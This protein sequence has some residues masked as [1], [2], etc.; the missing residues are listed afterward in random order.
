M[1]ARENALS[2]EIE[3]VSWGKARKPWWLEREQEGVPAQRHDY[4][5][6]LDVAD[7]PTYI[8]HVWIDALHVSGARTFLA[9]RHRSQSQ[10]VHAEAKFRELKAKW[11]E[12]TFFASSVVDR[13]LHPSYQ[14]IIG[15]GPQV[16]P[17]LLKDLSNEDSDWF[18]ALEHISGENPVPQ[19]EWG[20]RARMISRWQAWGADRGF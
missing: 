18:W 12:D 2:Y 7:A 8:A 19:Q 9:K 4:G 1:S 6:A 3:D 15:M 20:D 10:P 11:V 17:L 14:Q 13:V 16:I 5:I